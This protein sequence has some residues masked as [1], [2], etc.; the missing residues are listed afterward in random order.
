[1]LQERR[2]QKKYLSTQKNRFEVEAFDLSAGQHGKEQ[3]WVGYDLN[4]LVTTVPATRRLCWL[5][6]MLSSFL[7]PNCCDV[8]KA[9]GSFP[10]TEGELRCV[11]NM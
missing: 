2:K 1:V 11:T 5:V 8:L 10:A 3:L 4:S 7:S 6:V 9:A